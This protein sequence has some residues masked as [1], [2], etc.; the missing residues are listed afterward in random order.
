MALGASMRRYFFN[1]QDGTTTLDEDGHEIAS[2]EDARKLAV[3]HAGEI[4]KEG[5][6]E[7]LWQGE[8]W[9][10]W[11]TDAPNG[12]GNTLFTLKFSAVLEAS[13]QETPKRSMPT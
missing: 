2:L 9:R 4:L 7:G 12:A 6:S 3:E 5:A 10:M 8:H 13:A 11:V 1:V